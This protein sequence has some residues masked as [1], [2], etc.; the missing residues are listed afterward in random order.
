MTSNNQGCLGFLFQLFG[1]KLND[2]NKTGIDEFPYALRD[3]FFITL[4]TRILQNSMSSNPKGICY[5]HQSGF[6]GY[7]FCDRKGSK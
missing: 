1:V 7:F 6:K 5:L 4:R 2:P 3:D